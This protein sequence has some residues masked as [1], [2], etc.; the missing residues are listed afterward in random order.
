MCV[1]ADGRSADK[2]FVFKIRENKSKWLALGAFSVALFILGFGAG[3]IFTKIR[4]HA[5]LIVLTCL[6]AAPAQGATAPVP[7]ARLVGKLEVEPAT[8]GKLS[9]IA[10]RL[11]N[12]GQ[13]DPRTV[14]LTLTVT[15]LEK[16]KIVFAVEKLPI[17]GEF[18]T[19]FQFP[20][21]AE[22]R[23]TAAANIA[24]LG[25]MRNEQVISVT[26]IEPPARAAV[27]ALLY[28]IALIAAGLGVGRWSKIRGVTVQ[29]R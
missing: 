7:E 24:G 21:G 3:R 17:T 26:G 22:Y 10:W 23:V 27:P 20:D 15:H 5:A 14:L 16:G 18:A 6:L 25:P 9:R 1:A 11:E 12:D 8:V 29:S 4:I 13:P 2:T 28:F 19:K